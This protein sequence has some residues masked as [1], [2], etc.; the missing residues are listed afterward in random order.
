MNSSALPFSNLIITPGPPLWPI[1]PPPSSPRPGING[2]RRGKEWIMWDLNHISWELGRL[3]LAAVVGGAIGFERE[4]HGQAAGLRTFILVSVGGC[5]M[6]M[7][8]L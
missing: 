8:S 5:V 2:T 1:S 6:M 7:L 4:T 3:V